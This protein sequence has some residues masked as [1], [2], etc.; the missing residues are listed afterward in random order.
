MPRGPNS[1]SVS[2]AEMKKHYEGFLRVTKRCTDEH[3]GPQIIKKNPGTP[4]LPS[5]PEA[6][7]PIQAKG[8]LDFSRSHPLTH[9]T[10]LQ[11]LLNP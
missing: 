9:L 3:P 1:W 11:L 8:V 7:A 5:L 4:Q 10:H 2:F 6:A